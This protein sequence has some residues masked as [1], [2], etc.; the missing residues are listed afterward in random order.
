MEK[1]RK[2]GGRTEEQQTKAGVVELS[3]SFEKG[4][5]FKYRNA[6]FHSINSGFFYSLPED[7]VHEMQGVGFSE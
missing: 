6:F 7:S 5:H 1:E 3:L 2:R 4:K